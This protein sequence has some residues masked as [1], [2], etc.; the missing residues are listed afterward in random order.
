MAA[1]VCVLIT[2]A[3]KDSSGTKGKSLKFDLAMICGQFLPATAFL[4]YHS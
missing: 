3:M 1:F 2:D 4:F